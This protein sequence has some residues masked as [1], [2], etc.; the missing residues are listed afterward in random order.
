[1]VFSK[2][3]VVGGNAADPQL[4]IEDEAFVGLLLSDNRSSLTLCALP[5]PL[6]HVHAFWTRICLVM[7]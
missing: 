4:F 3:A 5:V 6:P 2:L 1:M 7:G